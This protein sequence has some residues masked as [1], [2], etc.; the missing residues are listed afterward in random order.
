MKKTI[1]VFV[2]ALSAFL[3]LHAQIEYGYDRPKSSTDPWKWGINADVS[4]DWINQQA[5]IDKKTGWRFGL[6]AE[7][8]LIY[9]IYFRPTVSF[10]KKG[11]SCYTQNN[12][13]NDV[14]AYHIY[15]ELNMEL[16]FGDEYRG[17]GLL[18]YF[19]PYFSYGI[20]GTSRYVNLNPNDTTNFNQPVDYDTYGENS[21]KK[22]D[23][24]FLFGA[25]YDINHHLEIN[26]G[27]SVGYLNMGSFNNFRWRSVSAGI[28]YFFNNPKK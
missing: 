17:R 12:F 14:T 2:L 1:S 24:G 16:K 21:V 19:A 11:F 20:A 9:N 3:T 22:E 8:H 23:L 4:L 28:T 18:V 26:F 27:F 15:S 5:Y 6:S 7:K 25:G 10:A 13:S